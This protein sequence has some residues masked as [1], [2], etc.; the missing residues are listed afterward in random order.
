M[1][2]GI[3]QEIIAKALEGHEDSINDVYKSIRPLTTKIIKKWS[4][5]GDYDELF[6]IADVSFTKAL[7]TYN[8]EKNVKFYNYYAMC[9]DRDM[10][11]FW[12]NNYTTQKAI[13]Y[14]KKLSLDFIYQPTNPRHC[15][16]TIMDYV[17]SFLS[18]Y[19]DH[20]DLLVEDLLSLTSNTK[21]TSKARAILKDVLYDIPKNQVAIKH[22]VSKSYVTNIV[23][24]FKKKYEDEIIS[25]LRG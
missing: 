8:L 20:Y 1:S 6:S 15:H 2:K 5:L 17:D 21:M 25:L 3:N 23:S 14:D 11:N 4:G 13:P 7:N 24:N 16:S 10:K 22:N 18:I 12:R 19:D 9:L